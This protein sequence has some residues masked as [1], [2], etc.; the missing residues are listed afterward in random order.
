MDGLAKKRMKMIILILFTIIVLLFFY[1]VRTLLIPF[2]LAFIITYLFDP[3]VNYFEKKDVPRWTSILGIYVAIGG[4]IFIFCYYLFPIIYQEM[5]KLADDLPHYF[6]A[7]QNYSDYF[8]KK[9]HDTPIPAEVKDSLEVSL[10]GIQNKF[11]NMIRGIGDSIFSL[12]GYMV[13]LVLAPIIAFYFL[14]DSDKIKKNMRKLIPVN[15]RAEIVGVVEEI[16]KGVHGFIRG[17]VLDNVIDGILVAGGLYFLG[18]D[19]ALLIGIMVAI[20]NMIPFLG[21][22]VGGIIAGLLSL[23]KSPVLTFKVIVLF[24]IVEQLDN[25]IINPKLVGDQT[26]LHP[27]SIIFAL[28]VGAD[29]AGI[30]GM[31]LAVPVV[32]V[33]KVLLQYGFQKLT[34]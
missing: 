7:V 2:L 13:H 24:L 18:M 10:E 31:L 5:Q 15:Y 22:I 30:L 26:N 3:V 12:L 17:Q 29:I 8:A 33:I 16:N 32:I 21:P 27:V 19:F 14:K 9:Y 20:I 11:L 28:L 34:S 25:S 23:L 6:Q 1:K 4:I